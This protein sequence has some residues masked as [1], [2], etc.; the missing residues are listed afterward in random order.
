M[1]PYKVFK[2]VWLIGL[3]I[4]LGSWF[5]V[6]L[7]LV[8]SLSL[9]VLYVVVTGIGSAFIGLNFFVKSILKTSEGNILLTFDDGPHPEYT[10]Q[11]LDAL[12][13]SNAKAM[14]FLIGD[15][16]PGNEHLVK[17]MVD[18]GHLIG[19]HSYSHPHAIGFYVA[20]KL[21]LEVVMGQE[22]ITRVTGNPVN[23]YRPPMGI[24]NPSISS[25]LKNLNIQ[26]VGWTLR[27]LDTLKSNSQELYHSIENKL[28]SGDI[29]LLHDNRE[30]TAQSLPKIIEL[31][32]SKGYSLNA[33]LD[34][35]K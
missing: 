7:S 13:A 18:E 32:K 24:T 2:Y 12:K 5:F 28:K 17:R 9:L 15:K 3:A 11:V 31:I 8:W 4:T 20:N 21:K 26:S 30:I 33:E 34:D 25:L 23:Y 10:A 22:M 14:F 6:D 1:S 27:T 16:I 29:V 35:Q 19:G